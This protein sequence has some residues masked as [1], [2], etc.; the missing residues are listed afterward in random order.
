MRIER[1]LPI[2]SAKHGLTGR[3]DVV[4]FYSDGSVVPVEYKSGPSRHV[5]HASIQLCAQALCL[6]EMFDRPIPEGALF[7]FAD[8][9]RISVQLD[10]ALR[11]DTVMI[12]EA[13]RDL[14][15]QTYLPEPVADRR[16]Q[17]CS[18]FDA[19]Q[20][21]LLSDSQRETGNIFRPRP[22]RDLP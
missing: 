6:E 17:K 22:P 5:V 21:H 4:E 12:V 1:A 18:L 7:F 3:A 2:W 13:V 16:C 19:C 20:P 10:E 14:M 9:Q 8:R 15:A 11:Q